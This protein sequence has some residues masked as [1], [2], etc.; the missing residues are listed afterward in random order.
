MRTQSQEPQTP[1][2]F[3]EEAEEVEITKIIIIIINLDRRLDKRELVTPTEEQH[4]KR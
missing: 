4:F 1:W 2:E 3:S